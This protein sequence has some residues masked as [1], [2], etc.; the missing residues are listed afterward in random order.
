VRYVH[1]RGMRSLQKQTQKSAAHQ[2]A[3]LMASHVRPDGI[4]V[5]PLLNKLLL[6]CWVTLCSWYHKIGI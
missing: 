3:G 5:F 4:K 1:V 2:L 6:I